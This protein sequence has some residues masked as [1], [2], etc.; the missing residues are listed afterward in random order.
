MKAVNTV[1]CHEAVVCTLPCVSPEVVEETFFF[2][3]SSGE[4]EAACD[5]SSP[6]DTPG[7]N[8]TVRTAMQCQRKLED[9]NETR[10][11]SSC[12]H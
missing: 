7:V 5:A 2:F 1:P 9:L 12:F 8:E 10:C 11:E 3:F 4:W 6:L